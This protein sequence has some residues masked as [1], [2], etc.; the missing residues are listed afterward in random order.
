MRVLR[1]LEYCRVDGRPLLLDL[2]LPTGAGRRRPAVLWVHGGGWQGG[3]REDA[4]V[5]LWLVGRGYAVASLDYRLS[6][7]AVFPAQIEDCKAAVRW[8]RAQAVRYHLDP[9]RIGA[10]GISAGGHLAAL[11]GTT[12]DVKELEGHGGHLEFSSRIQAA[13]VYCGPTDFLQMLPLRGRELFDLTISVMAALIGGPLEENEDKVARANPVTYVTP[14]DPPFL[15]MNGDADP[16]VPPGQAEVLYRALRKAGVEAA[17]HIIEGG[18]HIFFSS[19]TDR[20]VEEFFN[21]HLKGTE[22]PFQA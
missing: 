1:D 15:I 11:L 8:L 16:L 17:L 18:G 19:E 12:G 9:E 3:S 14:D 20:L 4:M 5:P 21:K 7:E 10:W 22:E 13:C 2:Y 6:G